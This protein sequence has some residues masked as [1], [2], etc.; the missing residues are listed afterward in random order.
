M[1]RF[2]NEAQA[3]TAIRNPGIVRVFDF[4]TTPDGRAYFVMEL[5]EGET[6]SAR[7]RR[8]RSDHGE[9]CRLGRQVANVLQ[10]A[11]EVGITHRDL[12]PDHLFLVTDREVIGGER[13][14][15]LDFG[16][17]KLAGEVGVKTR[18]GLMMGTPNYM[19]PEQCRSANVADARSDIYSLG[20]VM[21]EVVCGRPPFAFAGVGDVVAAHL[22]APP[23]HPRE[24]APDTP[25]GLSALILRMLAK[26]PNERPQ[27]MT[28]VSQVLDE[29]LSTPGGVPAC[30]LKSLPAPAPAS[31]RAHV[32]IP[33]PVPSPMS[34]GARPVTP[35]RAPSPPP[36]PG[37]SPM[38]VPAGAPSPS[39]SPASM[40]RLAPAPMPSPVPQL[41]RTPLDWV[42][43][44]I[45]R[46]RAGTN[47]R[48]FVLGGLTVAGAVVAIAIVLATARPDSP[49]GQIS[50]SKIV[51]AH[52]AAIPPPAGMADAAVAQTLAPPPMQANIDAA[53]AT[54][55]DV[56]ARQLEAQCRQ[57]QEER[58]WGALA[59]CAEQLKPLDTSRAAELT[60]RVMEEAKSAP[61]IAGV[62]AALRDKQLKQAKAELDQV[63]TQ[64]VDYAGIKRKYDRAEAEAIDDLVTRLQRV[65][66]ASCERYNQLLANERPMNPPRVATE[67]ARRVSC[68]PPP[69]CDVN[70][71]SQR[72]AEQF[73]AN[74]FAESLAFYEAAYAC[75]PSPALSLKAFVVACNLR[76]VPK[77]R[78]YWRR[79]AP[80]KRS[81]ALVPC[82]RN[83]II[84]ETLNEP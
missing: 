49:G 22:H 33:V 10:A 37:P 72:G 78:S 31:P 40:L 35:F 7:L 38:Q 39:P 6:L 73:V 2:F 69:K 29:I 60:D 63:W 55:P 64:S 11:H 82:V 75:S 46:T 3:A 81:Q 54:T 8:R 17:A 62:E 16:I 45:A 71:L 20:C 52:Q 28:A 48:L 80:E 83:G 21:F 4:G 9:C 68:A 30:T 42:V 57:Y 1:Q 36:S 5:L 59:K 58:S 79:L 56:T 18:T 26:H 15:V 50:Y 25:A 27:A 19:S 12:K 24:L 67:A 44:P 65:K 77:A 51:A 76:N 74:H 47:R 41:S 53:P 70:A 43:S 13:V 14:K 84:E 61:R 34:Q 32:P 23:P 66:D